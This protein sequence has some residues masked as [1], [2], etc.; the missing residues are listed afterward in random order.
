MREF[1]AMALVG[2]AVVNT[3]YFLGAP[4]VVAVAVAVGASVAVSVALGRR[5]R[6]GEGD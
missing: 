5:A 2:L 4:P 6:A 3:I 1:I